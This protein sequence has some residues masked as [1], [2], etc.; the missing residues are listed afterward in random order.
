VLLARQI[1][2]RRAAELLMTGDP[3]TSEDA[4]KDGLINAVVPADKLMETVSA[5]AKAL[6]AK[7][8]AA[9]RETKRLMRADLPEINA[10]IAREVQRFGKRLESPE[11]AEAAKAF[12]EKRA[13]DF[14]KFG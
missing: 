14:S 1:G 10:A 6:A 13:P 7:P 12:F 3:F 5:K 11:F 2:P 8:P 9:L 4:L